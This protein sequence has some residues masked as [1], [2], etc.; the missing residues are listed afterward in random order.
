[1]TSYPYGFAHPA[2]PPSPPELPEG[3][4]PSPRWPLWYAPV[5]FLAAFF[6]GQV[7]LGIAVLATGV[8]PEKDL[9][10]ALALGG[11][12]VQDLILIAAAVGFASLTL[13]PRLWHF[14]LRRTRFWPAVGWSALG[15]LAFFA[16]AAV[17]TVVL[18]I[19]EEQTTL[20]DLG[21]DES[22]IALVAGALLVIIVAPITEELFFRG[23]FYRTLRARLHWAAAAPIVGLVF[24]SIHFSTGVEAVP[25]LVVLGIVFCLIYERTGSLYP[26]IALHALNNSIAYGAGAEAGWL[27]AGCGLAMLAACIALPRLVGRRAPAPVIG[28]RAPATT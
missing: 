3:V 15:F 23:F 13:R 5:A 4:D 6:A 10:P 22:T 17:Y 16:F 28:R 7:L 12:F 11:T 27:A 14:G 2:P 19:D 18:D 24:G 9:P 1:M 8:D 25:P 26:C 21:T 20:E